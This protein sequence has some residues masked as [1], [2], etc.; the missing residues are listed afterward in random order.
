[1]L[2]NA[3]GSFANDDSLKIFLCKDY[4]KKFQCTILLAHTELKLNIK[5]SQQ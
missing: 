3:I 1:M 2:H 4:L 5:I